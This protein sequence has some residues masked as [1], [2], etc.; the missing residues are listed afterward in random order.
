L[1]NDV[2][3]QMKKIW[4]PAIASHDSLDADE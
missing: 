1:A 3:E 4:S 2:I